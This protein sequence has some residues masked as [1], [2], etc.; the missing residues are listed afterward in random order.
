MEGTISQW[1]KQEGD[2]IEQ[3]ESIVEV[4][5]DKVDTEVP[6]T[7]SGILQKILAQEGDVV[8]VG[9]PIAIIA[10]EGESGI[11]EVPNTA[12]DEPDTEQV[13]EVVESDSATFRAGV[14]RRKRSACY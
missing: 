14:G 1:L 11:E 13:A 5:T 8:E 3:E 9:K 4:A 2:L 7:H 6:A 12:G 10:Q